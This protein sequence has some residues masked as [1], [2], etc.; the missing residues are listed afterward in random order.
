M[1]NEIPRGNTQKNVN[2]LL[3]HLLNKHFPNRSLKSLIDVPCGEGE[4]LNFISAEFP[5]AQLIG[6]DRFSSGGVGPNEASD[7]PGG[8]RAFSFFK[9]TAQSFFSEHKPTQIAAITC[10]S[11][12]MCFDG[13]HE[14]LQQFHQA[15]TPGGLVV[16]TNDNIMT[17]RDRVNFLFFGHFKRFKLIY[18]RNEG[19]WNIMTPQALI[20]L[21]ERAH[22]V[23][24]DIKYTSTYWEDIT[25]LPLSLVLY[26]LFLFKVLLA[27]GQKSI[28]ERMSLY[29]FRSLLARHYVVWARK[30]P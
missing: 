9:Q 15:L 1:K 5:A 26:P 12:V 2:A 30:A 7:S 6:V 28:K 24:I 11:G 19:N 27:N 29:P 3:F 22:F 14:L 13:I 18:D 20:M 8:K 10:I 21:L 16:V 25:W 4:F 23:D 17:T